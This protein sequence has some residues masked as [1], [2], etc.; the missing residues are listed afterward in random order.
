MKTH[1]IEECP[2]EVI[3]KMPGKKNM[4]SYLPATAVKKLEAFLN[5][6]SEGY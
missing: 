3:V 4:H 5:K 6:Y 1:H 2:C